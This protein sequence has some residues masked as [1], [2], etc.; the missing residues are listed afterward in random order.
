MFRLAMRW[1]DK[2]RYF[3]NA[4]S[5]KSP[6]LFPS[7]ECQKINKPWWW[8]NRR[9]TSTSCG[10]WSIPRSKF[11]TK[12]LTKNSAS[13]RKTLIE[14]SVTS[15]ASLAIWRRFCCKGT[16]E[17][18]CQ[19]FFAYTR[20]L[21]VSAVW[22]CAAPPFLCPAFSPLKGPLRRRSGQIT[23]QRGRKIGCSQTKIRCK[24]E[25]SWKDLRAIAF[26][27]LICYGSI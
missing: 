14:K 23:W 25:R 19:P 17:Y 27:M 15:K 7:A 21:C 13:P 8:A 4:L 24:Y 6:K 2:L 20:W 5:H 16:F 10:L 12:R 11:L 9:E 3:Q 26:F 18:L 1:N 22:K